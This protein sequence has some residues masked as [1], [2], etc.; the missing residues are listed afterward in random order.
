[1]LLA[2]TGCLGSFDARATQPMVVTPQEASDCIVSDGRESRGMS[3]GDIVVSVVVVDNKKILVVGRLYPS[4][5]EL[6]G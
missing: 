4:H 1:M 5:F 2:Y 3:V 6:V